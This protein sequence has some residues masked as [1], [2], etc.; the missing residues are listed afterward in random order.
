MIVSKK[1]I[2]FFPTIL[3]KFSVSLQTSLTNSVEKT[4]FPFEILSSRNIF[5]SILH[6]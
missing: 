1:S 6:F 3:K 5:K 2:L 4:S